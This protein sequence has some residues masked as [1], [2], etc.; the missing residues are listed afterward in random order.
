MLFRALSE[1][2]HRWSLNVEAGPDR[3]RDKLLERPAPVFQ[4]MLSP[5]ALLISNGAGG[6]DDVGAL[7][8]RVQWTEVFPHH[9]SHAAVGVNGTGWGSLQASS[10]G[11]EPVRQWGVGQGSG[12]QP[13]ASI[14]LCLCPRKH[15]KAWRKSGTGAAPAPG[16][17]ASSP[18]I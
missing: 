13:R 18:R 6:D 2:R 4:V 3:W 1:S 16:R 10:S 14:L 8:G 17:G 9:G 12:S 7:E 15:D 5:V 11:G